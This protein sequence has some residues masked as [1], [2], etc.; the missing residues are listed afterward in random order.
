M[1]YVDDTSGVSHNQKLDCS[2]QR[3]KQLQGV[4]LGHSNTRALQYGL[5]WGG[6][7]IEACPGNWPALRSRRAHWMP[8]G[9][10]PTITKSAFGIGDGR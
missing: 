4:E 5:G 3:C 9:P 1:A 6:V 8:A 7:L 10:A 2:C